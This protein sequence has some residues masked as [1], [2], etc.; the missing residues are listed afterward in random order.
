[1]T[2]LTLFPLDWESWLPLGRFRRAMFKLL[3][4]L[5]G[6]SDPGEL[7]KAPGDDPEANSLLTRHE[8]GVVTVDLD[9]FGPEGREAMDEEIIRQGGIPLFRGPIEH[10]YS[11][12]TVAATNACP[13][14]QAPTEKKFAEFIYATDGGLRS[15]LAPA[16][17][18]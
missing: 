18:F 13:R 5:F 7:R 17:F 8:G 6:T 11:Q 4:R 16:G 1:M 10:A 15:M 14:C 3:K 2:W 9:S 12:G